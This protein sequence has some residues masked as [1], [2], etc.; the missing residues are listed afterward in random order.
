MQY[1]FENK[2]YS[3]MM[4]LYPRLI[5]SIVEF[6]V[7]YRKILA[8]RDKKSYA[9]DPKFETWPHAKGYKIIK[10][11]DYQYKCE[12]EVENIP[13]VEPIREEFNLD[14]G[15]E[16]FKH[17]ETKNEREE[18]D[19]MENV[20]LDNVQCNNYIITDI[21]EDD[22]DDSKAVLDIEIRGKQSDAA[23]NHQEKHSL[24]WKT[25]AE[26]GWENNNS[27]IIL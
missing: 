27:K 21:A 26:S 23:S 24:S 8:E 19:V 10:I 2:E 5:E 3:K 7:Y 20:P 15:N 14:Y 25:H 9:I 1:H 22:L 4:D 13:I 16:E 12:Q 17:E 11:K 6:R 18:S